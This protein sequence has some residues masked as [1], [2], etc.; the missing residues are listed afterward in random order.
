M[1]CIPGGTGNGG[2]FR[3]LDKGCYRRLVVAARCRVEKRVESRAFPLLAGST[4]AHDAALRVVAPGWKPKHARVCLV[5]SAYH[6][7]PQPD[8]DRRPRHGGQRVRLLPELKCTVCVRSGACLCRG[9]LGRVRSMQRGVGLV[10]DPS[11]TP[12]HARP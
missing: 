5:P 7:H 11:R 1:F 4:I 9:T 2:N 6:R 8:R 10:R 3:A 12:R